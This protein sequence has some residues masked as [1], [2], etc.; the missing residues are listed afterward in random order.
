MFARAKHAGPSSLS[1]GHGENKH[2]A[3]AGTICGCSS[4]TNCC[5]GADDCTSSTTVGSDNSG[6][7]RPATPYTQ[8]NPVTLSL[9]LSELSHGANK[10][11]RFVCRLFESSALRCNLAVTYCNI[12][13]ET[14]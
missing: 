10:N 14:R 1:H 13:S 11:S 4:T 3:S 12:A 2:G 5:L 8:T 7:C 9:L 6:A